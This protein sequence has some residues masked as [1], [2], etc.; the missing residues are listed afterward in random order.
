VSGGHAACSRSRRRASAHC[1]CSRRSG[2][3]SSR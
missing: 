2:S 3:G 1:A